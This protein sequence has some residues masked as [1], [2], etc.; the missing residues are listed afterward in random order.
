MFGGG[1]GVG[2][3]AADPYDD[4]SDGTDNAAVLAAQAAAMAQ[5]PPP[6]IE[7][8]K[9][10]KGFEFVTFTPGRLRSVFLMYY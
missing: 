1:R 4:W 2:N 3:S 10:T 5:I 6:N 8:M 7:T 9:V